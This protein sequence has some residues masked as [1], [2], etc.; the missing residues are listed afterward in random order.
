M[1]VRRLAL[2]L[3]IAAVIPYPAWSQQKTQRPT[4]P[5][6]PD[7]PKLGEG[8]TGGAGMLTGSASA[9]EGDALMINGSSVRLYGIDAPDPGQMCKTLR[10]KDYDCFQ[11]A[12]REL[13]A[14]VGE[15]QVTCQMVETG[16]LKQ[17]VGVCSVRG[18]DLAAAMVG[19]GWAFAYRRVSPKYATMEAFAQTRKR[20]MWGGRIEYPWLWRDRQIATRK[21]Q[22]QSGK[23]GAGKP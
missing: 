15:S 19:R 14:M 9:L 17:Q 2:A 13:Q 11:L 10:N 8:G 6:A 21:P 20:G 1:A 23:V 3:L 7:V 4:P 12:T 5:Q 22:T 16:G 18:I